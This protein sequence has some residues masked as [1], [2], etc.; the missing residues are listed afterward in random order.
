VIGPDQTN[1]VILRVRLRPKS[2]EMTCAGRILAVIVLACAFIAA[3][4]PAAPSRTYAV[5]VELYRSGQEQAAIA[6][7]DELTPTEVAT[8]RDSLLKSQAIE[9]M[10]VAVL[11]HSERAIGQRAQGHHLEYR[12]Q[13]NHAL[14]YIAWLTRRDPTA[15]F[16]RGWW[17]YM[18]AALHGQLGVDDAREFCNRARDSIGD[19]ADLLL[20]AGVTEEMGW[21]LH[22]VEADPHAKGDLKDAARDYRGAL[23]LAPDLV[24]ATLRLGRVLVLR[25]DASGVK[26]LEGIG[27]KADAGYAYLAR[28]FEGDAW[29]RAGNKA[30]AERQYL[31]AIALMPKAQSAYIALAHVR[32]ARGARAEAADNV[33]DTTRDRTAPDTSEPWFWYSRGMAWR[34]SQYFDAVREMAR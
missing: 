17:L 10:R 25:G 29:E 2:V 22:E 9:T 6:A 19:S 18:I 26:T 5:V 31:A 3:Q 7:L 28:L 11:L 34:A 14:V 32:H 23:A 13:I 16:V 8:G 21:D 15:P 30:D 33:R 20:A 4:G 27:E 1:R 24:E 12:S